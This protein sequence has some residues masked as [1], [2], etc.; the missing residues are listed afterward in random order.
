MYRRRKNKVLHRC[1][2]TDKKN[3][4]QVREK[5]PKRAEL[6]RASAL[7]KCT[8]NEV[9]EEGRCLC[10]E[11]SDEEDKGGHATANDEVRPWQRPS[12]G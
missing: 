2:F 1:K 4:R 3:Q 10:I 6:C 12:G 7:T 5:K 11:H 8:N 9:L